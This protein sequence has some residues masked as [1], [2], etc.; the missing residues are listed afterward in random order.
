M[1]LSDEELATLT[2][3]ERQPATDRL[4]AGMFAIGFRPSRSDACR[5][6]PARRLGC[7]RHRHR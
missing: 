4:P 1:A 5:A 6:G 2:E 3:V 7:P